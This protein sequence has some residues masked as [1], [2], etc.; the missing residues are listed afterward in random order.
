MK[1]Y[2]VIYVYT[3]ISVWIGFFCGYMAAP[4]IIM[5]RSCRQ[6]FMN[7]LQNIDDRLSKLDKD[8]EVEDEQYI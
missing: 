5:K 6:F 1:A 7:K 8:E 3:M 2:I 4:R